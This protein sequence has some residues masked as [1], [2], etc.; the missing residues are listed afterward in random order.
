MIHLCNF[1]IM[2]QNIIMNITM[3]AMVNSTNHQPSFNDSTEGLPVDSFGDPNNSPKSLPAGVSN[4]RFKLC[5]CFL[6]FISTF[7]FLQFFKI[8]LF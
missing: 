1:I 4:E 6:L 5:F 2:A 3:V 8:Y 7:I